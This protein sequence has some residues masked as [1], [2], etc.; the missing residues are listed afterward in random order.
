VYRGTLFPPSYRYFLPHELSL[1]SILH[2]KEIKRSLRTQCAQEDRLRAAVWE[3]IAGL[4]PSEVKEKDSIWHFNIRFDAKEGTQAQ[5]QGK[6]A[7]GASALLIANGLPDVC[8]ED[9]EER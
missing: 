3:E 8:R 4:P 7:T 1:R 9:P 6:C 2:R 5:E